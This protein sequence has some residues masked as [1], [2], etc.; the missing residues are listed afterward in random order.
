VAAFADAGVTTLLVNPLAADRD[1][2][3]RYVEEL[4]QLLPS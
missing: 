3:V 2:S 1:E 4:R